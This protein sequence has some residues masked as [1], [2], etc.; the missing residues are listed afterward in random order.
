MKK[1]NIFISYSR[2]DDS[3]PFNYKGKESFI[4]FLLSRLDK[5]KISY[6][7]D[8]KGIY[9]GAAFQQVIIEALTD[10]E[11]VLFISSTNSNC[12][13]SK[14]VFREII[15][16][17]ELNMKIIPFLVDE[18]PFNPKISLIFKGIDRI[19]NF[20]YQNPNKP[21]NH[22]ISGIKEHLKKV[23]EEERKKEEE[24]ERKRIEEE[25]ERARLAEEEA[26]R[27]RAE[28]IGKEIDEIKD[29]L[30]GILEK[31]QTYIRQL[32]EKEK[33]LN[34]SDQ[35]SDICPICGSV[36]TC[37]NLDFCDN[38]G[39]SFASPYETII[40]EM[41]KL[42]DER[43]HISKS[44]WD[45]KESN[46][47][48]ANALTMELNE[49]KGKLQKAKEDLLN[50]GE[51]YK[52][53]QK[54]Q[55]SSQKT[56]Q[57]MQSELTLLNSELDKKQQQLKQAVDEKRSFVATK[58]PVAFLLVSEFD[59]STV[60]CLYEGHNVFGSKQ[61][62]NNDRNYQ[63]LVVSD[64]SMN[65]KHFE[66]LIEREKKSC[67]FAVKPVDN[68]CMISLNSPTNKVAGLTKL[69]IYDWLLI[70]NVKIQLLDN[71]NK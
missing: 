31:E 5:E 52:N 35:D 2:K 25:K 19:E 61:P 66:I 24:E 1:N 15:L 41:Q 11:L 9:C 57:K 6:W 63:M 71:F 17:D 58:Q 7:I 68:T 46:K 51:K 65:S 48:K 16:A 36:I 21:I 55:D 59:L 70:G 22:L 42:F 44:V 54:Q 60:Y 33:E 67:V 4:D 13:A 50:V 26:E 56:I 14:W 49:A 10:S 37:N 20:K 23:R 39:W 29:R 69:Q 27:K 47:Q 3:L 28:R 40:P 8:R 43:L 12:D 53:A 64:G 45:D 34:K 30:K 18:T 32:Q 62:D 38:C